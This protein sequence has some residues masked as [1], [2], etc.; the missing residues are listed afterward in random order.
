MQAD[1]YIYIDEAEVWVCGNCGAYAGKKEEVAHYDTCK[2]G[3]GKKWE[4]YSK[5]NEEEVDV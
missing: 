3:E 4:I 1:E 2:P 5:A